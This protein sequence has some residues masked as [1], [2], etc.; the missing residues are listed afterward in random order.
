MGNPELLETVRKLAE[1][2]RKLAEIAQRQGA[3]IERLRADRDMWEGEAVSLFIEL[4]AE[5]MGRE[6]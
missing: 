3:S 6:G 5:Q 4:T 1:I 2:A